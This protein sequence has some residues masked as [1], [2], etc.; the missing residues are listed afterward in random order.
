MH[1]YFFDLGGGNVIYCRGA[2]IRLS[3]N[4]G[5]SETA[6]YFFQNFLFSNLY[7]FF[8]FSLTW[9]W[10]YGSLNFKMLFSPTISIQFQPLSSFMTNMIVMG[11]YSYYFF[12]A[13]CK[14]LKIL[15]HFE[16]FLNIGPY[17]WGWKFQ[18]ATPTVFIRCQPNFMRTLATMVEYRLLLFLAIGQV[19][20]ILWHLKF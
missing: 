20:Q 14:I 2:V 1:I 16:I 12:L 18:S 17:I 7:E 8:L 15:W 9:D 10:L 6:A 3:G 13:I 5:F 19:L 11:E 4:S